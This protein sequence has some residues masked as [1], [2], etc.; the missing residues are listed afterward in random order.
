MDI[1]D[2]RKSKLR[3][4]LTKFR[5]QK[6][7]AEAT[8]LV[9]PHVSQMING[10]RNVGEAVAR[11]IEHRLKLPVGYMDDAVGQQQTKTVIDLSS[12]D[13]KFGKWQQSM[14][15]A[16]GDEDLFARHHVRRETEA[17]LIQEIT[18]WLYEIGYSYDQIRERVTVMTDHGRDTFDVEVTLGGDRKCF[19]DVFVVGPD[20]PKYA[21][22]VVSTLMAQ[23]CRAHIS[24]ATYGV[25][26]ISDNKHPSL[27]AALE[28]L[29]RV[30]MVSYYAEVSSDIEADRAK[31]EQMFRQLA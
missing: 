26:L 19:I 23:A 30:N 10:H 14:R 5:N 6:E 18:N 24:G 9:A 21:N 13:S 28:Q 31:I 17:A 3:E 1:N 12:P 29:Q 22:Q 27:T 25:V 2:T 11:R 15:L 8:G 20:M 7:F 16:Q 4:L